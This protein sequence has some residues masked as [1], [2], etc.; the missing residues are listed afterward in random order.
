MRPTTYEAFFDELESIQEMEKDAGL[1]ELW[2]AGTARAKALVSQGRNLVS[3]VEDL[4]TKTAIRLDHALRR[5]SRDKINAGKIRK[6]ISIVHP[7][8]PD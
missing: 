1:R 8:M 2:K 7:N 5:V 3:K 6:A 4:D